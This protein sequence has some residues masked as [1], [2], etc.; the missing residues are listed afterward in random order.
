MISQVILSVQESDQADTH[1][2]DIYLNEDDCIQQNVADGG[3]IE[4]KTLEEAIIIAAEHAR[5][6]IKA[7]KQN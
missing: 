7:H 5:D 3:I 1:E 2:Y 4:E 6:Y